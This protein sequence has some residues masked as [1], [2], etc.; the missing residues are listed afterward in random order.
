LIYDIQKDKEITE[1]LENKECYKVYVEPERM[2]EEEFAVMEESTGE[3]G[4]DK[5]I[6]EGGRYR[7]KRRLRLRG[8]NGDKNE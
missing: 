8:G 5:K 3:G 7:K 6:G 1:I 2:K 4:K